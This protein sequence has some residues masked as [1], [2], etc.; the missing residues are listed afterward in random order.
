MLDITLFRNDETLGQIR[1][2]ERKR[3]R[4]PGAVDRVVEAD[5]LWR[6][7]TFERSACSRVRNIIGRL[8]GQKKKA[9]Q[10]APN[11][12]DITPSDIIEMGIGDIQKE[13]LEHLTVSQLKDYS[14]HITDLEKQ[15]RE[16]EETQLETRDSYL[17]MIGNILDPRVPI[18]ETEDDNLVITDHTAACPVMEIDYDLQTHDVLLQRI[19]GVEYR[20]GQRV[21]GN[22]G[23]YLRGPAVYLAQALTQLS[24]KILGDKGYEPIQTPFFMRGDILEKVAQLNDFDDRLYRVDQGFSPLQN[25]DGAFEDDG[26]ATYLIATSEQPLVALN[27]DQKFSKT[28]LPVRYAGISTCFRTETG[29]HGQDTAGIFRVHQ[30]DK[31]EQFV[32][33]D[34]TT[35]ADENS[36]AMMEEMVTNCETLLRSLNISYRIVS[37]VSKELNLAAAIKYD[38]EG[39]FPAS[40][41][42]EAGDLIFR[43]LVSC[44]NCTDYQARRVNTQ[45]ANSKTSADRYLHMLNS[46]M[47]AIP[48]MISAVLESNQMSKGIVVPPILRPYMPEKYSELIE[49]IE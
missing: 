12:E 2:S 8:I 45:Y 1:E 30:F 42:L 16:D 29:R 28:Q 23:Y 25:A 26:S 5:R 48:R 36:T 13:T 22:R 38:I 41:D 17:E 47:C 7:A 40:S 35:D 24:L 4:D 11:E 10:F 3:F 32:L 15:C 44:S 37:I 19:G 34:P 31:I 39:M 14:K 18:S 43:E 46:T 27:Q 20:A 33:A 6:K 49:Y 21:A 9:K